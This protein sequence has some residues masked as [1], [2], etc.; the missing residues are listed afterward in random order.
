M[1]W[2]VVSEREEEK[3]A[4][5]EEREFI[6]LQFLEWFNGIILKSFSSR[7]TPLLLVGNLKMWREHIGMLGMST[8]STTM[9]E[10][11]QATPRGEQES[12]SFYYSSAYRCEIISAWN[13]PHRNY[14][15]LRSLLVERFSL[16]F[17][18]HFHSA[19]LLAWVLW[20]D[21]IFF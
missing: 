2:V 3:K 18:L 1:G 20:L 13:I 12:E 15:S 10:S 6:A 8:T 7:S 21:S 17:F 14:E 9:N 11:E 19:G 5:R 16:S 4:K